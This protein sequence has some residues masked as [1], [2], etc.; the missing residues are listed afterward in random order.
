MAKPTL[1]RRDHE[2]TVA[3]LVRLWQAL[4]DPL[5]EERRRALRDI[6]SLRARVIKVSSMT[7][8]SAMYREADRRFG[9]RH[10]R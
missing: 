9:V 1:S 3:A 10:A 6:R 4:D 8:W 7:E 5:V 2:Q